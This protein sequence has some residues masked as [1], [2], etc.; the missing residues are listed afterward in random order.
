MDNRD[1]K[2]P[3]ERFRDLTPDRQKAWSDQPETQLFL[4]QLEGDRATA[5]ALV[6][7]SCAPNGI[8]EEGVS[9]LGRLELLDYL[10]LT[11]SEPS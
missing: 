5:Q 7:A 10:I 4:R 3:P 1:P 11:I 9:E 2:L 8:R 6:N